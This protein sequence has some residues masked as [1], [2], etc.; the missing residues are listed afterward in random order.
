MFVFNI[1]EDPGEHDD[2]A[3]ERQD[4]ARRLRLMHDNWATIV[5]VEAEA[6]GLLPT[7]Q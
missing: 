1:A 3:Y 6:R 5:T 7:D 2:L 4:V